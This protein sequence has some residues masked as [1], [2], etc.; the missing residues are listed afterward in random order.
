MKA[1]TQVGQSTPIH[2]GQCILT[3][4]LAATPEPTPLTVPAAEGLFSMC[5]CWRTLMSPLAVAKPFSPLTVLLKGL[6]GFISN[7][8]TIMEFTNSPPNHKTHVLDLRPKLQLVC[9]FSH[10]VLTAPFYFYPWYRQFLLKYDLV[11]L[12][13]DQGGQY[14]RV[15]GVSRPPGQIVSWKELGLYYILW[16]LL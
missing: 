16:W 6:H 2:S 3:D 1:G 14:F 10:N 4:C 5:H 7:D 13:T 12:Q 8:Q 15:R 11:S 9:H